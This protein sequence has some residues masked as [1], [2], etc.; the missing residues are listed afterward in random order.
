[1]EKML[2]R[3]KAGVSTGQRGMAWQHRAIQTCCS[4]QSLESAVSFF[5]SYSRNYW[6]RRAGVKLGLEGKGDVLV[7]LHGMVIAMAV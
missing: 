4:E 6:R 7:R 3:I 5:R 2:G 1:M